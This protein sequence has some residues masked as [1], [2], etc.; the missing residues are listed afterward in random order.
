MD[1]LAYYVRERWDGTALGS[2]C[3]FDLSSDE[4]FLLA[5]WENVAVD[6]VC[7]SSTAMRIA[8]VTARAGLVTT[9]DIP[10]KTKISEFSFDPAL[11]GYATQVTCDS[12]LG[13]IGIVGAHRVTVYETDS[14]CELYE[15][16]KVLNS[17][18]MGLMFSYDGRYV[19]AQYT[20]QIVRCDAATGSQLQIMDVSS[21]MN[22][23]QSLRQSQSGSHII[24][25]RQM[26][27]DF[28][29]HQIAILDTELGTIINFLPDSSMGIHDFL[30]DE[31]IVLSGPVK[32]QL[33]NIVTNERTQ[34]AV[35]KDHIRD[36][37]V[38]NGV[39]AAFYMV[40]DF[41]CASELPSG[42]LLLSI[43]LPEQCRPDNNQLD[44]LKVSRNRNTVVLM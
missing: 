10:A 2:V 12:I 42:E 21:N 15:F 43:R 18:P 34:T 31:V 32:A 20:Q 1:L 30:D 27:G 44:G 35:R 6:S 22:Y 33:C 4:N 3:V 25:R 7:L 11:L 36:I 40:A 24:W 26:L 14:G 37:G 23:Y 19:Y 29:G 8:V 41:I 28:S 5:A 16:E 38:I 9:F 13:K 17:P 39:P